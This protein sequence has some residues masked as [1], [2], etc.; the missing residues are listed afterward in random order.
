[1]PPSRQPVRRFARSKIP[2]QIIVNN[3]A[4]IFSRVLAYTR[5]NMKALSNIMIDY[6][7]H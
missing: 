4:F 1:M 7:I 3:N 5:E 2:Q 6:R